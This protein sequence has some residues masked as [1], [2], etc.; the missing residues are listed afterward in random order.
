[1]III[2]LGLLYYYGKY[3]KETGNLLRDALGVVTQYSLFY[4]RKF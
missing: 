4:C 3:D 2:L 1:M